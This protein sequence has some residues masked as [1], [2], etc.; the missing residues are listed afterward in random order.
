LKVR[1]G[2]YEFPGIFR[3][4][5]EPNMVAARLVFGIINGDLFAGFKFKIQRIN[6]KGQPMHGLR[7]VYQTIFKNFEFLG[8]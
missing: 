7:A 4:R 5:V 1:V 2:L 8:G 3:H 6:N